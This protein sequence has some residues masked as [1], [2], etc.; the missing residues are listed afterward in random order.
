ML[1]RPETGKASIEVVRFL[2][3]RLPGS[4][5][6][7][8]CMHEVLSK[9]ID[10]KAS[11]RNQEF[12]ELRLYDS[13]FAGEP[14]YCIREARALW[15]ED[16]GQLHGIRD[17]SRRLYRNKKPKNGCLIYRQDSSVETNFTDSGAKDV[18][19]AWFQRR[20]SCVVDHI[21][22]SN[23]RNHYAGRL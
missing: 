18:V 9:T 5:E 17:R 12:Y 6:H 8:S 4:G 19:V 20:V 7:H 16:A 2:R 22:S 23:G 21:S 11:L 13:D 3:L 1:L 14:V 10:P 15:D